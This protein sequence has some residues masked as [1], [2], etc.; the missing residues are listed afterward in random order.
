MAKILITGGTGYIGSHTAI[1]L[2]QDTR[3]EVISIDNFSNS[4]PER[5]DNIAHITGKTLQNYAI[6]L[7]DFAAVESVFAAHQDIVGVIHFAAFMSVEESVQNPLKYYHNNLN[8]LI[9]VLTCCE[10]F[11][12]QNVVY[13][14][15]CSVY[16]NVEKLPVSEET[17]LQP[18]QSPYANTKLIGEQMIQDFV[19]NRNIK[20]IFLR[21]FNPVGAHISGRNGEYPSN[22]PFNLLPIVVEV[23]AG[24]RKNFSIY[25]TKYPTRDGTCLRDYIHVSDI[26]A[27][28]IHALSFLLENKQQVKIEVFNVGSGDGVTVQEMVDAFENVNQ[29]KLTYQY[30]EARAGDVAAVYADN[31]KIRNLLKWEIKYNLADMVASAWQWQVYL[32]QKGL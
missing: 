12:V 27:A 2:L 5:L 32:Q 26:A 10:K 4:S 14:S 6:D 8:S 23:A 17:P 22:K 11:G 1:E 24:I 18:A 30:G 9:N 29:L 25:G 3:Y 19:K 16:G 31:T 21:Y 7:C 28:H 15:S 20:A 13:S